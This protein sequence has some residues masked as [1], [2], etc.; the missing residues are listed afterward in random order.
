MI[1][2][3]HLLPVS[4]L[5]L[6][7]AVVGGGSGQVETASSISSKKVVLLCTEVPPSTILIPGLL[8]LIWLTVFASSKVTPPIKN[9]R[10]SCGLSLVEP[11]PSTNGYC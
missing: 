8:A 5:N 11:P 10:I 6:A 9:T 3:P 7:A 2:I 1:R 4:F